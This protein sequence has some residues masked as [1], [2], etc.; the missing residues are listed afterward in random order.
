MLKSATEK[1]N[2]AAKF[3]EVLKI[4]WPQYWKGDRIHITCLRSPSL[5]CSPQCPSHCSI[6][7]TSS[8]DSSFPLNICLTMYNH[9]YCFEGFH[10]SSNFNLPVCNFSLLPLCLTNSSHGEIHRG[11]FLYNY[12]WIKIVIWRLWDYSTILSSEHSFN[13]LTLLQWKRTH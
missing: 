8:R 6:A 13:F 12:L 2:P 4:M 10:L 9:Y 1:S 5:N 7:N 11:V 3:G